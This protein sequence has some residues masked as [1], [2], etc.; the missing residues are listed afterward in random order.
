MTK[1]LFWGPPL[2]AEDFQN[3]AKLNDISITEETRKAIRTGIES[4]TY[5]KGRILYGTELTVVHD[6]SKL[7]QPTHQ[8]KVFL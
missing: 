8:N 3:G 2:T 7:S 4:E 6:R 5:N 1:I